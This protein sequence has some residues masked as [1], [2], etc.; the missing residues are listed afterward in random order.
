MFLPK[1][2]FFLLIITYKY[3]KNYTR[4]DANQSASDK[5]FRNN[6]QIRFMHVCEST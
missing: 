5:I 2:Y 4:S 3:S 6:E 1:K